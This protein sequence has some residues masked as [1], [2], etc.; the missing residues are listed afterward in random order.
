MQLEP[1]CLVGFYESDFGSDVRQY[2]VGQV[3]AVRY[4]R[5]LCFVSH[6]DAEPTLFNLPLTAILPMR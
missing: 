1:G 4:D 6:P 2:L 5:I 3:Y